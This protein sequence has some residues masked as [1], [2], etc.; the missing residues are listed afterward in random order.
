M[1]ETRPCSLSA[2]G[3]VNALGGSC[4]EIWPRLLAGD[5]S[6][7]SVRDDLVAGRSLI[8][9]EVRQPLPAVP[10]AL[11]RYACRNNALT[12]AALQQI[13]PVIEAAV[14]RFGR[15]RVGV[16]MG[17]STSGVSD[18]E[19][20]I[21][22]KQRTGKLAPA[23]RYAQLE[24]GGTA[25]FVA[26]YLGTTGP[27]YALSTACSS[28]ARALASARSLLALGVCDAVVA[29]ASDSLGGLTTGGFSALQVVSDAVTN[30]CSANRKGLTL[31]E[32]AA[33]FLATTGRSAAPPA[34]TSP[35]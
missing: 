1:S 22:H 9:A 7:L 34:T 18:A 29:G 13:E 14:R 3:M 16:V 19:R 6:G 12:L 20:A 30:P 28:G 10:E 4:G 25:G 8:L 17:T 21:A 35:V 11:A 15:E 32:G 2:L 5:Q 31:G 27:H 23:F 33:V 26:A 24:F